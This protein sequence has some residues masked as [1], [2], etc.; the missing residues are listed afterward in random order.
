MGSF[1]KG[2]VATITNITTERELLETFGAPNANNYEDWFSASTYLSYGGQ[3]QIVRI[4]DS[5]L[6]NS[7]S[8][9]GASS[10]DLTKLNV[11]NATGFT[12]GDYVKVDNE[13]FLVGVVT[14]GGPNSLAVTRAQLGSVA[15]DHTNAATVTKWSYAN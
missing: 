7:V 3:L 1:Q 15:V 14:L 4:N 5:N 13:Y 8:D 12:S 2:P 6:K 10:T 11:V 9:I